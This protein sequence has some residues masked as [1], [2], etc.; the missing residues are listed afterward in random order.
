MHRLSKQVVETFNPAMQYYKNGV[1]NLYAWSIDNISLFW[2]IIME[3]L[4]MGM[5]YNA[6]M[7]E[8]IAVD[9]SA[10]IST[11]PEWFRGISLNYTELMLRRGKPEDIAIISEFEDSNR[12]TYK[13]TFL[14]LRQLVGQAIISL[15]A[16]GINKGDVVAA[17][18]GN[19]PE[20]VVLC[21]ATAAIGALFTTISPEFGSIATLERLQQ[22]RP[23]FLLASYCVYYNGKTHPQHEKIAEIV[24]K[25]DPTMMVIFIQKDSSS[26]P[27]MDWDS[28]LSYGASSESN[29][30][31]DYLYEKFPFNHPLF[32]LYSSGTTGKPKCI[33]HSAGG[34][35]LQH[36]KEH[37]YH[38][39]MI[40]GRDSILQYTSIGWMMWHW[41]LSVLC[42]GCPI[43]LY[44]GS[45]LKPHMFQLLEIVEKHSITVLGISAKYLQTLQS[46]IQSERSS[47]LKDYVEGANSIAH[48]FDTKSLRMIYS[49]GSPL[50]SSNFHFV[51]RHICKHAQLASITG[52]T[53]IISLFAGGNPTRSVNAGEIQGACLGMAIDCI[54]ENQ[55]DLC[56]PESQIKEFMVPPKLAISTESFHKV[57]DSDPKSQ[58]L[59]FVSESKNNV[60]SCISEP[61]MSVEHIFGNDGSS[62]AEYGKYPERSM[63]ESNHAELGAYPEFGEGELICRRPF[64]SMPVTFWNDVEGHIYYKAY[65]SRFP[66]LWHHGDH[67]RFNLST[68]GGIIMLGRSDGVLNPAGVRFGSAE[69]YA[70]IEGDAHLSSVIKDS[71]AVGVK[72]PSDG[73]AEVIS[74]DEVVVLFLQMMEPNI[75]LDKNLESR[76]KTVIRTALSPRHVPALILEAP[77]IPYTTNGKKMEVSVKKILNSCA[78]ESEINVVASSVANPESLDFFRQLSVSRLL[79]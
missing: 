10:N 71:L 42:T 26:V 11:V 32:I 68:D 74:D 24:S 28:F 1:F 44:D 53:D 21:L 66:G 61:K 77:G 54:K 40:Q 78:E 51:Y 13:L 70:I 3:D 48:E 14:Q 5:E 29:T 15:K 69:L 18:A 37:T 60:D 2:M 19:V 57:V 43:I 73:S 7:K 36:W 12:N 49:T 65:F 35:I 55:Y 64:P 52:G 58:K 41:S 56:T 50:S 20:V 46:T 31:S 45:P 72:I 76:I 47:L 34:T 8:I 30:F 67:V 4:T 22:T 63:M 79:P 23:K 39:D 25:L 33:V 17:W 59:N 27:Q 38:G 75:H 9:E 6:S 62:S 16:M